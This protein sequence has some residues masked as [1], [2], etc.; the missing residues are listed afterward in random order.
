MRPRDE[1]GPILMAIALG[2]G[3]GLLLAAPLNQLLNG[4]PLGS[5]HQVVNPFSS[6]TG[7]GEKEV[8]ILGTDV[9]GGTP[10]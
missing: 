2:L 5:N 9:G 1:R 6:W 7:M 4:P 3:G 10:M 8:V